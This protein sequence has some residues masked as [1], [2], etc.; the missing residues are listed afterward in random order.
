VFQAAGF[1]AVA[2][3]PNSGLFVV[4]AAFT[5]M[6]MAFAVAAAAFAMIVVAFPMTAA[7]AAFMA[8][9]S[10]YG[11]EH[12]EFAVDQIDFQSVHHVPGFFGDHDIDVIDGFRLI[13]FGVDIQSDYRAFAAACLLNGHTQAV[14]AGFLQGL[15]QNFSGTVCNSHI[16]RLRTHFTIR[17]WRTSSG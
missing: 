7:A 6:V 8:A 1:H 12:N 10:A 13:V 3:F 16:N 4:A 14:G 11:V 15:L 5:V 9:A 2:L 17:G